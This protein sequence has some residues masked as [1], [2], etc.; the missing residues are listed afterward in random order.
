M[1]DHA[2]IR[3]HQGKTQL[4][5]RGGVAP[6]G[7]DRLTATARAS[8]PSAVVWKGDPSLPASE[9]GLPS[10]IRAPPIASGQCGP[11]IVAGTHSSSTGSSISVVVALILRRHARQLLPE[12]HP[13]SVGIGVRCES[14]CVFANLLATNPGC[15]DSCGVVGSC[16]P[17]RCRWVDWASGVAKSEPS[18]VLVQLGRLFGDHRKTSPCRGRTVGGCADE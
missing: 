14:H 10:R 17:P 7:W 5:N 15:R 1:C 16:C 4:W 11:Q 12:S 18:G 9:Q 13:T 3:L 6:E 8:D 2:R